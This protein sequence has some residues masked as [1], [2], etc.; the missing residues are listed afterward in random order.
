[1]PAGPWVRASRRPLRCWVCWVR[2][3]PPRPSISTS[4]SARRRT[5]LSSA[6]PRRRRPVQSPST[7]SAPAST[8][9]SIRRSLRSTKRCLK[10]AIEKTPGP[11]PRGFA[12]AFV[13]LERPS[14]HLEDRQRQYGLRQEADGEGE[15]AEDRQAQRIDYQMRDA[16]PEIYGAGVDGPCGGIVEVVEDQDQRREDDQILDRV[17]VRE[18]QPV[19][20]VCVRL[21]VARRVAN[22]A[23][24]AAHLTAIDDVGHP[25]QPGQN[26]GQSQPE[27]FTRHWLVPPQTISNPGTGRSIIANRP[28]RRYARTL[29]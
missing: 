11:M 23:G 6:R 25:Q 5:A 13:Y 29:T 28:R 10:G 17:V 26:H 22:G 14:H 9:T 12:L 21:V 4:T 7:S 15:R 8:T 20:P 3:G 1:M 24:K 18:H 19:G 16:G 2:T 27:Q